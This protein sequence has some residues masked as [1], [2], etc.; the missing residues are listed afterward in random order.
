MMCAILDQVADS[1]YLDLQTL[2]RL[3]L[4]PAKTFVEVEPDTWV[5]QGCTPSLLDIDVIKQ[6]SF[7]VTIWWPDLMRFSRFLQIHQDL[8]ICPANIMTDHILGKF[9]VL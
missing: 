6:R 3:N 9:F 1:P 8:D 5:P 2:S 7:P 4:T